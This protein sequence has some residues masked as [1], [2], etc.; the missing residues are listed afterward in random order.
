MS[1]IDR[2]PSSTVLNPSCDLTVD[3]LL[4]ATDVSLGFLPLTIFFGIILFDSSMGFFLIGFPYLFVGMLVAEILGRNGGV[5]LS[6]G[7]TLRILEAPSKS[8]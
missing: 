3:L 1:A 6:S 8:S 2:P 5:E 4:D 7:F